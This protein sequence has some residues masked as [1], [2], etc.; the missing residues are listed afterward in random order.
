[1]GFGGCLRW[2]MVAASIFPRHPWLPQYLRAVTRTKIEEMQGTALQHA[3]SGTRQLP[4]PT[5]EQV[6]AAR[7]RRW[8]AC[9][10]AGLQSSLPYAALP[11]CPACSAPQVCTWHTLA[12]QVLLGFAAPILYQ[13]RNDVRAA[14]QHAERE[15]I[16]RDDRLH[17]TFRWL[18]RY[19]TSS[20]ALSFVLGSACVSVAA[21]LAL[22]LAR[23]GR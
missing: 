12:L 15:G 19:L 6:G 14:L 4:L 22:L 23:G 1:M 21:S 13:T 17:R 5:E 11:S 8:A 9:H 16:S 7:G 2:P 10:A 3:L 20:A 18:E